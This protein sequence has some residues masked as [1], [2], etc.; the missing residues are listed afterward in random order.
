LEGSNGRRRLVS[1][2]DGHALFPRILEE[3][4]WARLSEDGTKLLAVEADPDGGLDVPWFLDLRTGQ[5]QQIWIPGI[6]ES[7]DNARI[8]WHR[9]NALEIYKGRVLV[10]FVDIRRA[11]EPG[12][13]VYVRI[14]EPWEPGRVNGTSDDY[15]M[16]LGA[17]IDEDFRTVVVAKERRT[18]GAGEVAVEIYGQFHLP[19][20][21]YHQVHSKLMAR[22]LLQAGSFRALWLSPEGSRLIQRTQRGGKTTNAVWDTRSGKRLG[23]IPLTGDC[24]DFS[25]DGTLVGEKRGD[26]LALL[27]LR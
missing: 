16:L 25:P 18:Q 14:E 11:L 21:M 7:G 8:V 22:W 15:A 13:A 4:P 17:D 5:E 3:A 26:D 23:D 24:F 20:T 19:D 27:K 1:L 2:E 9:R 10:A 12:T 6:S